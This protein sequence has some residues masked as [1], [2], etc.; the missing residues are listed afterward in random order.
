MAMQAESL[1]VLES[2]AVPPA[3]ARAIVRA[4]EIE[5][6]GAKDVLATK[7]DMVLLRA[8]MVEMISSVRSE[9]KSD[10]GQLRSDTKSEIGQ[11]RAEMKSDAGQL[12]SDMQ[13]GQSDLRGELRAELHGAA[14]S[15]TRQMYTAM[16]G[17]MAV[18]L[19]LA[20]FFVTR[21]AG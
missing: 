10:I 4:I 19:G 1:E 9:L 21:P 8:E 6:A 15:I 17:Q 12:R 18:L 13:S 7:H 11:L 2:A 3:Q 16:L 5:I 14:S 20:Y